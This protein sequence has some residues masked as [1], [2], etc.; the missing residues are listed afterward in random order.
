MEDNLKAEETKRKYEKNYKHEIFKIFTDS[1][2]ID[3]R[4]KTK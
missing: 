2:E 1:T 4:R 3:V